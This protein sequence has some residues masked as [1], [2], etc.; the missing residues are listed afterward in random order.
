[1]LIQFDNVRGWDD[2]VFIKKDCFCAFRVGAVGFGKDYYCII[3]LAWF[4]RLYN[5]FNSS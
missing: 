5:G 2:R 3:L 4:F 1:M